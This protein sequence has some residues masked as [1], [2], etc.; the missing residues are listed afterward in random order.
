MPSSRPQGRPALC[1]AHTHTPGG[2]HRRSHCAHNT[3]FPLDPEPMFPLPP[4][5]AGTKELEGATISVSQGHPPGGGITCH[6]L[7]P[8]VGPLN[9]L[10]A[11]T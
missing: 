7:A 10:I 4:I 3:H 2:C 1:S 8:G 9:V 5:T 6:E 11:F